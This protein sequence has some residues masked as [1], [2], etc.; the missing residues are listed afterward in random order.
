MGRVIDLTGNSNCQLLDAAKDQWIA[1]T[2]TRKASLKDS[3]V[4]ER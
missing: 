4:T 3:E 2:L 1:E